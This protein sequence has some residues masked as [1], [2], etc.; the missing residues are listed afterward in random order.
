MS[1]LI[2]GREVGE[3]LVD[4]PKVAVL[5]ATGSTAMGKQVAPKLAKRF[6]RAILELGGNNAAIVCPS[7]D[8]DLTL[9]AVAFAAMGT[10]GQRCTS[11]RRLFVHSSVYDKLVPRL[12]K[13]YGSVTIG[14]PLHSGILVGPLIDARAF[15]A[16][17]ARSTTRRRPAAPATAARA[18]APTISRTPITSTRLWWR[19]RSR[20]ARSSNETF[21]PILYVM[22]YEDFDEALASHNDVAQ[23]LSSSIF[24]RDLRRGRAL[25]LGQRLGL[26]HRQRQYRPLGRRDRRCL[27]RRE[28]NRRRPRGRLGFLEGLHAPRHQHHQ[29]RQATAAG[30]G[31]EV[32]RRVTCCSKSASRASTALSRRRRPA[33]TASSSAPACSKAA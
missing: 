29:L 18:G 10:A 17:S 4:H 19:C 27:R 31:R 24:T 25:P 14:N 16:W 28:G 6:A 26:R 20:P 7:A 13:A 12:I 30:P 33:P 2:G 32:R 11:L 15:R 21:A 9:R 23:G 5:S 3:A 8:L 1:L 22:K